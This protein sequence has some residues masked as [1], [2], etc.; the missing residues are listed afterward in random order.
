MKKIVNI[1]LIS[2][3]HFDVYLS[4]VKITLHDILLMAATTLYFE[5]AVFFCYFIFHSMELTLK[6]LY[7]F[8]FFIGKTT[9]TC[10]L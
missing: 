8:R 2:V 7:F 4:T 6:T 5:K 1:K 9:E 3:N 10:S